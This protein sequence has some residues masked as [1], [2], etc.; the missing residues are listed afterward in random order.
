M[1]YA[2]SRFSHEAAHFQLADLCLIVCI[3][4]KQLFSSGDLFNCFSSEDKPCVG[5]RKG[6]NLEYEWI[7]Y[8]EV[9][10]IGHR[11]RSG[12]YWTIIEQYSCQ[13]SVKKPMLSVNSLNVRTSG[14]MAVKTP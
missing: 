13:L 14:N 9:G 12:A 6:P 3:I 2:K 1:A 5:E 11:N 4:L 7:T 10:K 8:Q